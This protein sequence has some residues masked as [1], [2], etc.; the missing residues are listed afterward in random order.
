MAVLL[1]FSVLIVSLAAVFPYES[2]DFPPQVLLDDLVPQ[3]ELWDYNLWIDE[4][5]WLVIEVTSN[6]QLQFYAERRYGNSIFVLA[7]WTS[8]HR[9]V[10]LGWVSFGQDFRIS[11][12]PL[13]DGNVTVEIIDSSQS[14]TNSIHVLLASPWF[15]LLCFA[16]IAVDV[17][18]GFR[19]LRAR[20][21]MRG[22]RLDGIDEK[23]FEEDFRVSR[24][25]LV[26]SWLRKLKSRVFKKREKSDAS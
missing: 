22:T 7:S 16:T 19:W 2:Y 13:Q 11:V 25:Y 8:Y 4:G 15:L 3:G 10:T 5:S 17:Y 14:S 18:V 1:S 26:L 24:T 6:V 9:V 12:T 20:D 21:S 23:G